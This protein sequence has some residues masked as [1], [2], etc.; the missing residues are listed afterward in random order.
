MY[1]KNHCF[2]TVLGP[3]FRPKAT[4]YKIKPDT[5]YDTTPFN[6]L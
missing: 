1:F 2:V 6:N 3:L 4:L 5:F